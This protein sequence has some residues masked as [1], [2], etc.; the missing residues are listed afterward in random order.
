VFGVN[1]PY[2]VPFISAMIGSA[3]AA[4][5]LMF[6]QVRATS[7]GVGGLPGF[8]SIPPQQWGAFFI[9]MAIALFVPFLLTAIL[10]RGRVQ[11][12]GRRKSPDCDPV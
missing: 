1:L 6:N 9:G 5:V 10:V 7:V 8:L 11:W 12:K 3:T 2:R 4:V